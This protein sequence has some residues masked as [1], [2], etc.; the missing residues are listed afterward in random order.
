MLFDD[1][2]KILK[3]NTSKEPHTKAECQK[4]QTPRNFYNKK[5]LIK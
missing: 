1:A 4:Y 2:L 5:S 3:H